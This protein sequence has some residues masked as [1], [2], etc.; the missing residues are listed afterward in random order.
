MYLNTMKIGNTRKIKRIDTIFSFEK[1]FNRMEEM[2]LL[3]YE[4]NTR[5]PGK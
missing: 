2:R 4:R 3:E 1:T 5:M